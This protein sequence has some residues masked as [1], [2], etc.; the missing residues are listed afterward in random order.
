M[1]T[2]KG[3]PKACP[4]IRQACVGD[5]EAVT[6]IE[7]V[8]FPPEQA[9]SRES[10]AR[11]LKLFGPSF[12]VAQERPDGPVIGFINGTV[13]NAPVISDDMYEETAYEPGGDY[14]MIFGLDV[15]PRYR[16]QG[17]ARTL[18]EAMIR[19]AWD[20]GRRGLVLTCK[21]ELVEFYEQFGYVNEGLSKSVH[22]G[23]SWYD[24][25]LIF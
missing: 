13:S 1:D 17:I 16:G 2:K 11:R 3:S 22:G 19:L 8:C 25:R 21:K 10:L 18:M 24:M 6:E 12:M 9:A 5:L 23:V 4:F 15:L 7:T 14:Q 20:E